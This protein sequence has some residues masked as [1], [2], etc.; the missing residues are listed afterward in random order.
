MTT[1]LESFISHNNKIISSTVIMFN[2]LN[3]EHYFHYKKKKTNNVK[4]FVFFGGW[5]LLDRYIWLSLCY[6]L[7]YYMINQVWL[8]FSCLNKKIQNK[9]AFIFGFFYILLLPLVPP[10]GWKMK[11]LII[12]NYEAVV[13]DYLLLKL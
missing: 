9:N 2:Y 8:S 1:W 6:K 12:S 3:I 7:C 4:L 5:C 10:H 11:C 13:Q